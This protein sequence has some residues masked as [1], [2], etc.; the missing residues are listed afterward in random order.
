MPSLQPIEKHL[1]TV[2]CLSGPNPHAG[3]DPDDHRH[4]VLYHEDL[5][6]GIALDANLPGTRYGVFGLVAHILVPSHHP[7]VEIGVFVDE[8]GDDHQGGEGV[9]D[10]EDAY[11]YHE[12]LEFVGLGAVV[13][14]HRADPEEGHEARGEEDR[15]EDE[16]DHQGDQ[17]EHAHG[18]DVPQSHVAY[19]AEDI[20]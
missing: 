10:G 7:V 12:L 8:A 15:A 4:Q 1:P 17:D 5:E 13:F 19:S 3:R 11:P 2:H 20:S 14:H 6:P 16:V 18:V 9:E